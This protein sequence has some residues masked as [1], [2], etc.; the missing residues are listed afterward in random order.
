MVERSR[1]RCPSPQ[2]ELVQ[3]PPAHVEGPS[4]FRVL[5]GTYI[6]V[7]ANCAAWFVNE[8]ANA[9]EGKELLV[10]PVADDCKCC[11]EDREKAGKQPRTLIRL[12]L[13]ITQDKTF[14]RKGLPIRVC[15]F[16]DGDALEEAMKAHQTRAS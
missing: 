1:S 15:E 7:M 5:L 10:A 2:E 6:A 3:R 14:K 12:P 13:E 11:K 16:C 9:L 4:I 8:F